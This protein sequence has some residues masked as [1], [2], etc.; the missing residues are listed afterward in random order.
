VK[1]AILDKTLWG[2][3]FLN[4][5]LKRIMKGAQEKAKKPLFVQLILE[6]IWAVY[7]AIAVRKVRSDQYSFSLKVKPVPFK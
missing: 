1:E 3:F 5:K 4:T 7:D 6:N 2:D